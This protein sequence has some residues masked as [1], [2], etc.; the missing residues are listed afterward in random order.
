MTNQDRLHS[1]YQELCEIHKKS[2]PE[3]RTSQFLLNLM[4][5]INAEYGDPFF[6][7]D[8]KL[9]EYAKEYANSHSAWYQGW[10]ILNK[11]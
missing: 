9:L 7:E 11:K 4:G 10:D 8:D 6:I 2:F 1:V 3:M 5:W